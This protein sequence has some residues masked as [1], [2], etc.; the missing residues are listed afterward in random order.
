[1]NMKTALVYLAA[2]AA[3]FAMNAADQDAEAKKLKLPHE[4]HHH[5]RADNWKLSCNTARHMI[6]ERGF[7]P[8][9]VKSCVSSVYSFRAMRGARVYIFKVDSRT[10]FI[11]P[12]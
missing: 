3:L 7:Y 8:V 6:M 4:H 2:I 5:H 1:M 11:R 12:G 9:K 10:G